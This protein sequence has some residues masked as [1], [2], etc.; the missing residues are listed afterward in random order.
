MERHFP[1]V[2]WKVV[3]PR[4]FTSTRT[5]KRLKEWIFTFPVFHSQRL[6]ELHVTGLTLNVRWVSGH[7]PS[8]LPV[9]V[10][11]VPL[12]APGEM[13]L[14]DDDG[15]ADGL[16][17]LRMPFRIIAMGSRCSIYSNVHGISHCTNTISWLDLS[18]I[19]RTCDTATASPIIGRR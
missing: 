3:R 19:C 13:Y 15:L 1:G 8:L 2:I 6:K 11:C 10:L 14:K 18:E 16:E 4:G 9:D 5:R 7:F 12:V 17:F